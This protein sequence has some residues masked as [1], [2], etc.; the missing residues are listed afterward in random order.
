MFVGSENFGRSYRL[1]IGP[2]GGS[3]FETSEL[4]IAFSL[5]KTDLETSNTARLDI[6]NLNDEHKTS[7]PTLRWRTA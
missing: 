2:A 5:E 1:M 4:H 6:W 7:S 3:G